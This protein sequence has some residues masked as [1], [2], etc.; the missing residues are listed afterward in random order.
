MLN[1]APEFPGPDGVLEFADGLGLDLADAGEDS[2]QTHAIDERGALTGLDGGSAVEPVERDE[3][4]AITELHGREVYHDWLGRPVL[5]LN[6]AGD[7]VFAVRYDGFGRVAQRR[8]PW[9]PSMT[10]ETGAPT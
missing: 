2:V 7:A 3:S 10:P 1:E 6:V 9:P 8:A 5:A 4:G